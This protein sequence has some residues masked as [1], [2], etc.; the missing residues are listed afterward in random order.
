M[1]T[2]LAT[3]SI[4]VVVVPALPIQRIKDHKHI[5]THTGKQRAAAVAR[6]HEAK[7]PCRS[8]GFEPGDRGIFMHS[9][10]ERDEKAPSSKTTIAR[11]HR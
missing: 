6:A 1:N 5:Y 8:P 2:A 9:T 11:R 10:G 7:G 4:Y 3:R